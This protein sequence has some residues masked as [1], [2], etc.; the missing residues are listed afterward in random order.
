MA[1]IPLKEQLLTERFMKAEAI[2]NERIKS[3]TELDHERLKPIINLT[4][5]S[6]II[7]SLEK[8]LQE[9]NDSKI[10][11]LTLKSIKEQTTKLRNSIMLHRKVLNSVITQESKF[12][13]KTISMEPKRNPL[14]HKHSN[15]YQSLATRDTVDDFPTPIKSK[16]TKYEKSKTPIVYKKFMIV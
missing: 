1:I 4:K 7:H 2:L 10:G 11:K 12:I 9:L 8:S 5:G 16:A 13:R 3:R 6:Y 15:R 14:P